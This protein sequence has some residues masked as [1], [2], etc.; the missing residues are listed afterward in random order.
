MTFAQSATAEISGLPK[1]HRRPPRAAGPGGSDPDHTAF[2]RASGL[3]SLTKS[4]VSLRNWA[5]VPAFT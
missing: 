4:P 1:R 5:L 3:A 2:D